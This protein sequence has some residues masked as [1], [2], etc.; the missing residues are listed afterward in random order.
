MARLIAFGCSFTRGYGLEDIWDNKNKDSFRRPS[1]YAWP[2]V[3]A[4]LLDRK[5]VN[6]G[7]GGASNKEIWNRLITFRFKQD[8]L[9][10]VNWSFTHRTGFRLKRFNKEQI[11]GHREPLSPTEEYYYKNLYCKKQAY[12]EWIVHMNH[13]GRYLRSRNIKMVNTVIE[14]NM[15][16]WLPDYNMETILPV[17]WEN[18]Q[19]K[20][21]KAL[22]GS[23]P[24]PLA[25]AAFAQRIFEL[26]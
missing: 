8:D 18:Y 16:R 25:H 26:I 3:L 17:Y 9:V 7:N 11:I 22:D 23:H 12:D 1:K 24:G 20:Y 19:D 10:V 21:E 6:K 15:S 2:S 4:Q 14:R 5:C 13:A